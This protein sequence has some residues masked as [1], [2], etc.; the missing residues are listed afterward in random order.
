MDPDPWDWDNPVE[1]VVAK[2]PLGQLP[3]ELTFDE[4]KIIEQ[5]AHDAGITPHA[6]IKRAALAAARGRQTKLGA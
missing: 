4:L 3:I 1:V 5:V 6:F 2:H